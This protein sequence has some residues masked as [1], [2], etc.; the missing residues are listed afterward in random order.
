MIM[1][2]TQI[3]PQTLLYPMPAVLVGSLVDGKANFMTVAWCG[4][5]CFQ[6]PAVSVALNN[7]RYTLKGIR[8]AG[9]FSVNVPSAS[10]VK[11]V[12][13]CGIYSGK[14]KDKSEVFEVFYG[15]TKNAPLIA[16]CPVNLECRV[17]HSLDLGSHSLIVGEIVEVHVTDACM[18]DGKPDP[19]KIDPLVYL[20]SVQRYAKVGAGV[21]K[22]FEVGKAE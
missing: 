1:S 17:T 9:T 12:D 11:E 21:A 2:K 6:P 16:E 3:G 8:E 18:T 19:E 4:I 14:K 10:Q 15:G 22:A 7:A 20:T 5:A 13:F